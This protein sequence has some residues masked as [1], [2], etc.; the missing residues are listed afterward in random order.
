MNFYKY[1]R[2]HGISPTKQRLEVASVLLGK[3]QHLSADQ[4]LNLLKDQGSKISKATV[5]NTL[6]LF[7]K[8]GLVR[9]LNIDSAKTIF[10]STTNSH[11][12]FYNIDTGEIIDIPK[13][14]VSIDRFPHLPKGT[15]PDDVEVL[16][17]VR[18]E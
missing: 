9:E 7:K 1:L 8:G 18:Q 17:K 15:L 16:I 6:N 10:D 12:H 3:P 14:G 5:Y 11:H 4:V 2:Q 13:D